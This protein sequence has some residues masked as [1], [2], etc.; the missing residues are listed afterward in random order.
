MA[1]LAGFT[2]P[3]L[4]ARLFLVSRTELSYANSDFRYV[5][6]KF[7]FNECSLKDQINSKL[8]YYEYMV[9]LKILL[10]VLFDLSRKGISPNQ[11]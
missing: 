7:L 6:I 4:L 5:F 2:L 11:L 9:Q 10:A 3:C 1:D 8:Q